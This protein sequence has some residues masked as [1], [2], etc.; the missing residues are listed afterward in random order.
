[1][2]EEIK[3]GEVRWL[4]VGLNAYTCAI[5]HVSEAPTDKYPIKGMAI[6]DNIPTKVSATK[7][8]IASI[9]T[10]SIEIGEVIESWV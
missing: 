9:G 8:G 10:K 4:N 5:L 3:A 2:S 7:E 6:I 1:M